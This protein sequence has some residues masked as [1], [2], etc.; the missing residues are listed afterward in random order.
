MENRKQSS[1]FGVP[2]VNLEFVDLGQS[3][4]DV[5]GGVLERCFRTLFLHLLQSVIVLYMKRGNSAELATV[6]LA[7]CL[8]YLDL[9]DWPQ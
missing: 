7:P 4:E 8:S 6:V 9:F 2:A 5:I 3:F 1:S